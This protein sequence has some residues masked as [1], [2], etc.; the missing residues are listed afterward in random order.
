MRSRLYFFAGKADQQVVASQ[1]VELGASLYRTLGVPASRIT[2]RD[3]DL[4]EQ[5]R[6]IRG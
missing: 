3:R 4:R 1:S 6:D 2:F 5:V